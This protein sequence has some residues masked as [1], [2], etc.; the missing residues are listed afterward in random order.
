MIER[1]LAVNQGWNTHCTWY[2]LSFCLYVMSPS[3]LASLVVSP[4]LWTSVL[5]KRVIIQF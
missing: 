3:F 4:E 5:L 2:L 1:T